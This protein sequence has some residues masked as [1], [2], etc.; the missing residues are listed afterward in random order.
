M[1]SLLM[2]INI[3]YVRSLWTNAEKL[4][5]TMIIFTWKYNK[6]YCLEKYKLYCCLVIIL[7][8]CLP[9]SNT[10]G[11]KRPYTEKYG[12]KRRRKR[13]C[14]K[15]VYDYSFAPYFP[16]HHRISP[17]T[18]TQKYDRNTGS[19]NTPKYGRKMNVYDRLRS[20]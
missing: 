9:R 6:N 15:S 10:H 3:C 7:F 4:D 17:H 19:C 12:D 2:L 8:F 11:R 14:T 5:C 1:F 18:V 16:V 20:V 13:S